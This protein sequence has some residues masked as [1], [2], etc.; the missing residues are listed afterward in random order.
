M[1]LH[2][3]IVTSTSTPASILIMICFTTS[4][5]AFRLQKHVRK[6]ALHI[7]RGPTYSINLLWIL[8]S[9]VSQVLL[10]SPQGVFLVVTL[11]CFVGRRTG[12]FTRRSFVLARS[13]SSEQ[14]FS[15]DLTLRLV[16]VMRI[17]CI[18]CGRGKPFVG[19]KCS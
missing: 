6:P 8:I 12:P 16:R 5:G 11:R 4:V 19:S 2:A 13:M 17:L 10:P 14:T 15:R 9:N 3:A 7:K 18:F 1:A